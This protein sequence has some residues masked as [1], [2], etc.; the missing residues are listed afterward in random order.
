MLDTNSTIHFKTDNF[1]LY[2]YSMMTFN[3][4]SK[5]DIK[6]I[7]IDLYRNLPEDNIQT[8]FEMKFVEMGKFIHY[9]CLKYKGE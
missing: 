6:D 8:E 3:A 9:L 4:D 5:Y 7:E 2:Q 1:G